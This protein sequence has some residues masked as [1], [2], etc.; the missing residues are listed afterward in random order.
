MRRAGDGARRRPPPP[1]RSPTDR[2]GAGAPRTRGAAGPGRRGA[3]LRARAWARRRA[4]P[5]PRRPSPR[6]RRG[7]DASWSRAP[8]DRPRAPRAGRSPQRPPAVK[9]VRPEVGR[10]VEQLALAAGLRQ[11]G[12]GHVG[13]DVELLRRAPTLASA[14]PRSCGSRAAGD[15]AA[16]ASRRRSRCRRNRVEPGRPAARQ[17]VED[18]HPA[19][20]HMRRD[21]RLLELEERRVQRGE[22]L[23]ERHAPTLPR[24]RRRH[25]RRARQSALRRFPAASLWSAAVHARARLTA[26]WRHA[27]PPWRDP[28]PDRAD[29]ARAPRPP[30]RDGGRRAAQR[31]RRHPAPHLTGQAIAG[32]EV[33]LTAVRRQLGRR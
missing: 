5:C 11:R 19:D 9:P 13:G 21:V 30:T 14:G 22:R 17:G 2:P 26:R 7:S 20:V 3:A 10:P 32:L 24:R 33:E 1:L 8:S 18:E 4:T 12:A 28:R 29:R 27:P 23:G 16:A 25:I 31:A 6:R 15:S